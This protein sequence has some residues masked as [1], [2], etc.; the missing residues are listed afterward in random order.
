MLKVSNS[1]TDFPAKP[2]KRFSTAFGANEKIVLSATYNT[3]NYFI[4]K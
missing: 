1:D 3:A 2:P 4:F